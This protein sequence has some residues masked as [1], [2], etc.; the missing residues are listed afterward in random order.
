MIPFLGIG[1]APAFKQVSLVFL[2]SVDR[3]RTATH[4]CN[5]AILCHLAIPIYYL[6]TLACGVRAA[7]ESRVAEGGSKLQCVLIFILFYFFGL[8][9]G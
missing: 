5:S 2:R 9:V 6:I 4:F 8:R 3:V 1:L 7:F